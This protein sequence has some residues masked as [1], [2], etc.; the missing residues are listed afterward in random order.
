MK[1]VRRKIFPLVAE[2]VVYFE[3]DRR[4][5]ILE[6][7]P[8]PGTFGRVVVAEWGAEKLAAL[9][10]TESEAKKLLDACANGERPV[11]IHLIVGPRKD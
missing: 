4:L 3:S 1:K 2:T 5:R 10:G 8:R 6:D 7:R 11:R 9:V